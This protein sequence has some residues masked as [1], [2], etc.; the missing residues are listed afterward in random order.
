MK[1]FI[2]LTMVTMIFLLVFVAGGLAKPEYHDD[3][4]LEITDYLVYNECTDELILF[5]GR[6]HA[7]YQLVIDSAGGVHYKGFSKVHLVGIG[8]SSGIEYI[9]N[10]TDNWQWDDEILTPEAEAHET[11]TAVVISKGKETNLIMHW[12]YHI[13]INAN[14]EVTVGFDELKIKCT[15]E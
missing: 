3:L 2:I 13:T 9:G 15:G 1:K 11:A 4:K 10:A 5:N 6:G 8:E 14:G 12:R 7:Q